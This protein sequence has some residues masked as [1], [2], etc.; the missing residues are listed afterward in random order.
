MGLWRA[1]NSSQALSEIKPIYLR[2]ADATVSQK[3]K[4]SF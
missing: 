4:L 1:Q 3:P 2:E